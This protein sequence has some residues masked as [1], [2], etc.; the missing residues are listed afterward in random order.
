M[1][2]VTGG[3]RP[4]AIQN[5]DAIIAAILPRIMESLMKGGEA[6]LPQLNALPQANGV[7][8]VLNWAGL[9]GGMA[10]AGYKAPGSGGSTPAPAP[11]GANV[12]QPGQQL[13]GLKGYQF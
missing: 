10:G 2:Q 5:K 3:A 1:P 6:S 9:I 8:S 13:P 7:D 12:V 4:S 11:T